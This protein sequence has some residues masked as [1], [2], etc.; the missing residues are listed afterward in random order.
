MHVLNESLVLSSVQILKLCSPASPH[1][2]SSRA[3][4]FLCESYLWQI[5]VQWWKMILKSS[6]S[7]NFHSGS[8]RPTKSV[9]C[10]TTSRIWPE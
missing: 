8:S 1:H 4:G 3:V 10:A 6:F 9:V 5:S 7:F 2:V